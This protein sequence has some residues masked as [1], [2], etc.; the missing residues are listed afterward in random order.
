MA[1][2]KAG[3]KTIQIVCWVS[4]APEFKGAFL[5]EFQDS[6]GEVTG[7]LWLPYS[8]VK[9]RDE[10]GRTGISIKGVEKGTMITIDLPKWLA[11]KP[12]IQSLIR[13]QILEM[14]GMDEEGEGDYDEPMSGEEFDDDIPF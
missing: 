9:M 5:A 11:D 1:Y 7:T 14:E 6:D 10:D 13:E 3:N 8:Q 2:S 12:D 4:W